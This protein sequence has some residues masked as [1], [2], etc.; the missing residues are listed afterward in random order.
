MFGIEP[1]PKKTKYSMLLPCFRTQ[2]PLVYY[3]FTSGKDVLLVTTLT[4]LLMLIR[5]HNYIETGTKTIIAIFNISLIFPFAYMF[6]CKLG[7]LIN[8]KQFCQNVGFAVT[9]TIWQRRINY[10]L[11]TF[12]ALAVIILRFVEEKEHHTVFD[13]VK[14]ILSIFFILYYIYLT[15]S[16]CKLVTYLQKLRCTIMTWNDENNQNLKEEEN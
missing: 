5:S 15:Y 14:K 12:L 6:R 10:Y 7:E 2:N 1:F 8:D 16:Y 3:R 13:L 9:I 11:T 4:V